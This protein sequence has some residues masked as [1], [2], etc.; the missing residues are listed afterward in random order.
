MSEREPMYE[1]TLAEHERRLDDHDEVILG[2]N[3]ALTKLVRKLDK[4]EKIALIVA[5]SAL[6]NG[7][8]DVIKLFLNQQ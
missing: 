7:G 6:A 3:R 1:M 8:S 2:L 4:W 5:G